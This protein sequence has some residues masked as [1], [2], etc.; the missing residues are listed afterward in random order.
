MSRALGQ[1]TLYWERYS[2]R[3]GGKNAFYVQ[4]ILRILRGLVDF[5]R[6]KVAQ[7]EK[8]QAQEREQGQGGDGGAGGGVVMSVNALL[9]ETGMD[10]VN[11]FKVVRYMAESQIAKKVLGFAE[12]RL[13]EVGGSCLSVCLRL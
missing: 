8:A 1:V 4:Q 5:V 10:N 12:R 11:L 13:A 6:R 3:L 7:A 9:F 2:A